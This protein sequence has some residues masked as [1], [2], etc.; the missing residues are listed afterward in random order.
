M[1]YGGA[2]NSKESE[3]WLE[4]INEELEAN[5]NN[6]T[7]SFVDKENQRTILKL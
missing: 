2:I 3:L 1:T 6:N 4:A 7:W 5:R